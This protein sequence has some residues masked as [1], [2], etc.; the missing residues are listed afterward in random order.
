MLKVIRRMSSPIRPSSRYDDGLIPATSDNGRA[1]E[2]MLGTL[3]PI[4][5]AEYTLPFTQSV[6]KLGVRDPDT[7]GR[8]LPTARLEPLCCERHTHTAARQPARTQFPRA[9]GLSLDA[10]GIH[11]CHRHGCSRGV[12]APAPHT[13]TGPA[14]LH[15]APCGPHLHQHVDQRGQHPRVRVRVAVA[16]AAAAAAAAGLS[17]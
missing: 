8:F 13:V 12:S 2:R 17:A 16:P 11:R 6:S 4:P 15:R 10:H 7:T 9:R 1:P 5:D 3:P 14:L